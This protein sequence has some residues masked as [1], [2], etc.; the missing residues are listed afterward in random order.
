M[1]R[2]RQSDL[3]SLL[4]FVRDCYAIR[5][6]EPFEHFVPRLLAAHRQL[7]PSLHVTYNEMYP[8]KSESHNWV[9]TTELATPSMDRLWEQHMHEHPVLAHFLQTDDR[10]AR[11]ISDFWSQQR[12]H[13]SGMHSEFCRLC[14]IE[15]SLCISIP[16]PPPRFI[17]IAW[18]DDRVFTDRGRLIADLVRPHISQAWHNAKLFRRVH[19]WLQI[20]QNG[21]E[22]QGMGVLLC[23]LQGT[24]QFVNA[25][26]RRHLAEY[27]GV[28]RQTDR[29]LPEELLLW[30]RHQDL[31]L[32]KSDNALA[33]RTPMVCE[34]GNKCLIIRLF[35]QSGANLI[36]ME[37]E[38]AVPDTGSI[39]TLGLTVREAEVLTWIARGKTN[40]EIATILEMR[41]GTVKKHVEHILLKLGVETRT[42]AAVLALAN[43]R[44]VLVS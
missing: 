11:R 12:L 9:S 21:V 40:N 42:A 37:E 6:F 8:E 26:A 24:V 7:I 19:H 33:V 39:K 2:L 22:D 41:A 15:D 4:R 43:S 17:G 38:R 28:T 36:L 27:F 10:H 23:K 3:Q 34:K 35:S 31:L 29:R 5:D 30:V 1:E 13:Q 18:H 20:L 25:Q 16:C 32:R 14:N 44:P